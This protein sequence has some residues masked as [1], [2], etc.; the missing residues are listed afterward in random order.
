MFFLGPESYSSRLKLKQNERCTQFL[1]FVLFVIVV[2]FALALYLG[3]VSQFSE[4]KTVFFILVAFS[5]VAFFIVLGFT[6]W[7]CR[8]L[9][10]RRRQAELFKMNQFS[11]RLFMNALSS[12]QSLDELQ[13]SV[14]PYHQIIPYQQQREQLLKKHQPTSRQQQQKQQPKTV[15]SP[16]QKQQQQQQQ[17][18]IAEKSPE[19]PPRP[20]KRPPIQQR[21]QLPPPKPTSRT[22]ELTQLDEPRRPPKPQPRRNF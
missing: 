15:V 7:Q 10:E 8:K 17:Q 3:I 6:V 13:L 5:F 11:S 22:I 21:K 12:V 19:P 18:Q 20:P 1:V 9:E 14:Q 16:I 2:L 4:Q